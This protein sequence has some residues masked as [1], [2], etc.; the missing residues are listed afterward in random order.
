MDELL[1]ASALISEHKEKFTDLEY[2]Q[3]CDLL[4]EASKYTLPNKFADERIFNEIRCPS[5][6]V[7]CDCTLENRIDILLDH[8]L[9][10]SRLL[11]LVS[12]LVERII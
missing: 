9:E 5:D 7:H 12:R 11:R 1:E 2:L 6:G 3:L 10:C 4:H 8:Y